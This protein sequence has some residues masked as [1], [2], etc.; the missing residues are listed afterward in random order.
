MPGRWSV[1]MAHSQPAITR[2]LI[3]PMTG[4]IIHAALR[5]IGDLA[6]IFVP[7]GQHMASQQV[8]PHARVAAPILAERQ[9]GRL[10][11]GKRH[12]L[13]PSCNA[14]REP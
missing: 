11:Q 7:V 9:P 5:H 8:D 12:S 3:W 6:G 4:A 2:S 1:T 14:W 10:D 13:R